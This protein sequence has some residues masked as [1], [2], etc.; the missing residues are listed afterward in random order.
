MA[1]L[2]GSTIASTYTGLLSVSGAVGA[3]T[4]EAVTDGAGTSTSL[5]LSQQRA[6]ITLGSG[7][8]D[9]FIVDGT[10]LV[11]EGDNNRVGIGTASPA[12]HLTIEGAGSQVL[13]IYC[14]D[15]G[16]VN[17][18]KTFIKMYGENTADEK[19]EQV[20]LSSAPGTNAS[21]AGQLIIST[22]DTD[23]TLDER[24]RIDETG[25][26]GIGDTDPSEAKLSITGV[27]SGDYGLKVQ[28]TQATAALFIDQD[29]A[30]GA[31]IEIDTEGEGQHGIV[32]TTPKQTT[33]AVILINDCDTVTSGSA[34]HV[35]CAA[36]ALATTSAA[37]LVMVNYTG[38][39]T[40]V[41]NLMYLKNDAAAA[42]N[43][44][45]LMI[46]QD[47]TNVVVSIV[48]AKTTGD[49]IF[50]ILNA[51]ALTTGSGL[52][53]HSD[54]DD[55]STRNIV[56]I[57]ND[58]T[59]ANNA[60]GLLIQQDGAD[61]SIELTGNGSIKFPGTQGASSD[62]NSLDDYEEGT[63]TGVYSLATG[64]VVTMNGSYTTGTYTKIGNMV[65]V[66]GVFISSNLDGG[67][68]NVTLTGLPF[69]VGNN[70]RNYS[71]VSIGG[72]GSLAI[73]ANG[74]ISGENQPNTTYLNLYVW[75][76]TAGT[77]TLQHDELTA[78]G[79]LSLSCT[80]MTS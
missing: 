66:T 16:S 62:A 20:R 49:N 15:T 77:T 10:T 46:K 1:T 63:W 18:Q 25:N 13:S 11:V 39:S 55:N 50:Q 43:T 33:G 22:N 59:S 21:S 68:G 45:P 78:D 27:K 35:Q 57:V 30:S 40:A 17:T 54:S 28:Q 65:T 42:T 24:M 36:P 71:A 52:L 75:D 9:D 41:S 19:V 79:N 29:N 48:D 12:D 44:I 47:S 53:V 61:A 58:D 2:T 23:T 37:G 26:V 3:D 8:A 69:T 4:V 60:V 31:A 7:A 72:G 51:D 70:T 6:T 73:T 38:T 76:A 56:K 64:G 80:Y 14:T 5:S 74:S 67:S 34:I 32:F